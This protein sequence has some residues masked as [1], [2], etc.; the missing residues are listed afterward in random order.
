MARTKLILDSFDKLSGN[1]VGWRQHRRLESDLYF[2]WNRSVRYMHDLFAAIKKPFLGDSEYQKFMEEMDAWEKTEEGME[3]ARCSAQNY[4]EKNIKDR[5]EFLTRSFE[6]DHTALF[7]TMVEYSRM[8]RIILPIFKLRIRKQLEF[9]LDNGY[10]EFIINYGEP[11]GMLALEVIIKYRDRK[12]S[13][14]KIYAW[15][16]DKRFQH[17]LK[18]GLK[19]L[20]LASAADSFITLG[21]KEYILLSREVGAVATEN[22]IVSC[23]EYE[24]ETTSVTAQH[25]HAM[26]LEDPDSFAFTVPFD[27]LSSDDMGDALAETDIAQLYEVRRKTLD[28]LIMI[29][30]ENQKNRGRDSEPPTYADIFRAYREYLVA[31]RL[32]RSETE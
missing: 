7:S 16:I 25:H 28:E 30:R 18:D 5:L 29:F 14:I 20:M 13:D 24:H 32:F 15:K 12:R 31:Y 3:T 23:E 1:I 9:L 10:T 2:L 21:W 22:G 19:K 17:F 8:K 4:I 6:K 27:I 11:Y 26:L